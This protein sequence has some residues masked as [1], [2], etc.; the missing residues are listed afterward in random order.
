MTKAEAKKWV[1]VN[2]K[3]KLFFSGFPLSTNMI[4]FISG[5]ILK[6]WYRKNLAFNC[7]YCEKY[8]DEKEYNAGF[9]Y[10]HCAACPLWE[11]KKKDCTDA[12]SPYKR[13][14]IDPTKKNAQAMLD[15]IKES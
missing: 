3:I 14:A 15:A 13:W 5:I 12:G 6:Y 2:W 4:Y 8:R 11:L 7:A 9:Y 1:I 10:T